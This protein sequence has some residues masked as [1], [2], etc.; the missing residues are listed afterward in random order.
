MAAVTD[1]QNMDLITL[2]TKQ[3]PVAADYEVPDAALD[4]L[5]LGR[6]RTSL[7]QFVERFNRCYQR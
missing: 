1:M 5:I 7:C 4:I 6:N 3:Y 2:N